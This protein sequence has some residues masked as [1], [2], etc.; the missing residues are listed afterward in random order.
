MVYPGKIDRSLV[1]E[2]AVALVARESEQSLTLRRLAGDLGVSA[3]ALYRY[4]ESREVLVAATADAV[5]QRL[6]A[7]IEEAMAALAPHLPAAERIRQLLTTYMDFAEGSP[8]LYSVFVTAK[9]EAAH[10]LPGP[11]YHELL[12]EQS[13]AII[14][15]LVG[16]DKGPAATVALWGMVHGMWSLRQA[17]VLGG[18]KPA[19]ID[20][21]AFGA[22]I[23]GL[24]PGAP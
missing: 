17:G 9:H 23:A 12:W 8:Q 5:G 20:A 2:A 4:F 13:L 15:P 21:Y 1:I 16:E 10:H 19:E 14:A 3:N 7:V 11:K 6:H 18:K 24:T 22:I